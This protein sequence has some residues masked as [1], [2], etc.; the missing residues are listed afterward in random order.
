MLYEWQRQYEGRPSIDST[1][2]PFCGTLATERHHIVYRSQG[3][4]DLPTVS[5]CGHGNASGC[6]GLFHQHRLH[7]RWR[8]GWEWL[9]TREP[10]KETVAQDLDG[11]RPVVV[12]G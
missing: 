1:F 7:L 3:G 4:T 11:W 8:D 10:T 9:Y 5:V 2:C 12:R 6:H